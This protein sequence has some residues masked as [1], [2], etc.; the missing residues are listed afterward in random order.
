MLKAY[1]FVGTN[2]NIMSSLMMN[3]I[4]YLCWK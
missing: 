3:L 2:A 1:I 4:S